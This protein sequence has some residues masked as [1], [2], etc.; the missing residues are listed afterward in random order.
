MNL[1]LNASRFLA[2]PGSASSTVPLMAQ[3]PQTGLSTLKPVTVPSAAMVKSPVP[4]AP[5]V[6]FNKVGVSAMPLEAESYVQGPKTVLAP[7][8]IVT[9]PVSAVFGPKVPLPAS[10]SGV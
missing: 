9:L 6:R 4:Y 10:C 2:V 7:L 8:P 5:Q 3:V 1:S